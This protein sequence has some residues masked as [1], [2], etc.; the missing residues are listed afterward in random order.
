MRNLTEQESDYIEKQNTL[1][2]LKQQL[3]MLRIQ[4]SADGRF[5]TDLRATA[6]YLYRE[7][8]LEKTIKKLEADLHGGYEVTRIN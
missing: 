6:Y 8:M 5:E 4:A 3:S 7:D 2:M 1:L